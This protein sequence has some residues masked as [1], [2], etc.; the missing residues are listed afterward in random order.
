M[1]KI[2]RYM[3][4]SDWEEIPYADSTLIK[5]IKKRVEKTSANFIEM[6]FCETELNRGTIMV[7]IMN[8]NSDFI[9]P[10]LSASASIYLHDINLEAEKWGDNLSEYQREKKLI[11]RAFPGLKVSSNFR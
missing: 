8:V 6:H 7:N 1:E 3:E 11:K 5:E 4:S 2:I 9:Y 10:V